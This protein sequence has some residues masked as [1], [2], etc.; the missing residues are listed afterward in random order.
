MAQ[1]LA[2]L[3]EKRDIRAVSRKEIDQAYLRWVNRTY[4]A[5]AP[6]SPVKKKVLPDVENIFTARRVFLLESPPQTD[7]RDYI[8]WSHV[9]MKHFEI[10]D[11][12]L[13]IQ[14]DNIQYK[15]KLEMNNE[16]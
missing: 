14:H 15:A 9:N 5:V 16:H 7:R 8:C 3:K 6:S 12:R 2:L 4:G 13:R 1:A 10:Y 11:G